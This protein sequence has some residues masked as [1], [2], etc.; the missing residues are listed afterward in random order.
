VF[1]TSA[2]VALLELARH[3]EETGPIESVVTDAPIGSAQR[4]RLNDLGARLYNSD[5]ERAGAELILH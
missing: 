1:A 2:C 5:T 4:K 3:A